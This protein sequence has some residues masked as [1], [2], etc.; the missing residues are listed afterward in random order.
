MLR[1]AETEGLTL[2]R[3]ESNISGLKI[4]AAMPKSTS[5]KPLVLLPVPDALPHPG[6]APPP[7]V[8]AP[9]IVHDHNVAV[10]QRCA[11]VAER[12]RV[13]SL[14]ASRFQ[15][16]FGNVIDKRDRRGRARPSR[17]AAKR[18][19]SAIIAEV[20]SDVGIVKQE[21]P[22]AWP[23][24][25]VVKE[26]PC[27][28]LAVPPMPDGA[29]VMEEP[30]GCRRPS[31]ESLA[32]SEV[33]GSSRSRRLK[34]EVKG[35]QASNLQPLPESI[36]PKTYL[37]DKWAGL[38]ELRGIRPLADGREQLVIHSV[39]RNEEVAM[40]Y[41]KKRC[42]DSWNSR[43]S[44]G[45][46]R[47]G[48]MT[49]LNRH[50]WPPA[51]EPMHA[52]VTNDSWEEFVQQELASGNSDPNLWIYQRGL[53]NAPVKYCVQ[54]VSAPGDE[55]RQWR[56]G[57]GRDGTIKLGHVFKSVDEARAA[58]YGFLWCHSVQHVRPWLEQR[59]GV[60]RR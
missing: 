33:T 45:G 26:E 53:R 11:S 48:L 21:V 29:V 30:V 57:F 51:A 8:L 47:Q 17:V 25:A 35:A 23:A 49:G 22:P 6:P 56:N 9:S 55:V 43:T 4:A 1:Q 52:A 13:Q 60:T 38:L 20:A 39:E 15:R 50:Y 32:P 10:Q 42:G 34:A 12:K 2:L 28:W 7:G 18:D 44:D 46:F 3:V 19:T 16:H 31:A 59:A 5:T 54:I 58:V 27:D 37:P 40:A 41:T 14:N 36:C 24:G